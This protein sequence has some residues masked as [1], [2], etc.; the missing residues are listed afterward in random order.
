MCFSATASFAASGVL[1]LA[2]VATLSQ[3]KEK[4]QI[5]FA[6][7][8]LLFGVQQFFE[9]FVWLALQDQEYARFES[10]STIVF[11]IFAQVIWPVLVPLSILFIERD[12]KRKI[13]LR[14][15]SVV[16]LIVGSFLGYRILQYDV[17]AEISDLHINY[18]L[19]FP[20]FNLNYKGI[21]YFV[22]TVLPAPRWAPQ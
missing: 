20:S 10:V 13:L 12:K 16:G 19:N 2:G 18:I 21:L 22:A 11:L 6:A 4:K 9:G 5:P 17:K 14:M 1:T 8:P 7:I 15:F 3:V